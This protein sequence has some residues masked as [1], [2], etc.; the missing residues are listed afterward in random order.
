MQATK[1]G[2]YKGDSAFGHDA[3]VVMKLENYL[4]VIEKTRFR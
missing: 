3:D 1:A 2:N 4:P